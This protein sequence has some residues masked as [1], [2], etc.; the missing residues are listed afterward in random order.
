MARQR[1]RQ[2]LFTLALALALA[3]TTS[4]AACDLDALL[5]NG[6]E[7]ASDDDC[8]GDDICDGG[9]CVECENDRDCDDDEECDDGEC[10]SVGEGE[11]EGEEGEG[12]GEGE[13]EEGEG[14]GEGEECDGLTIQG[15]CVGN[16]LRLCLTDGTVGEFDCGEENATCELINPDYGF[17]C[18]I[19]SG[20]DCIADDG[21]GGVILLTCDGSSPGCQLQETSAVCV[22]GAG[23]CSAADIDTC[24]GDRFIIGCAGVL[25]EVQTNGQAAFFDCAD[26]SASCFPTDGCLVTTP[27]GACQPGVSK[28]G[29]DIGTAVD[30]PD[31]RLC[32]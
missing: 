17:D 30:C 20:N 19:P 1:Q 15:E 14:E 22:N 2:P 26:L 31:T 32:P 10:E 13:G 9:E 16:T 11:G 25:D 5:G 3:A 4:L 8:S 27:A 24:D 12:E 7:C 21:Q 29:T 28:C 18:A 6:E 23:T